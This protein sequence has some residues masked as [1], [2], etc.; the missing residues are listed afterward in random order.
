MRYALRNQSKILDKFDQKYLD[1]II[2]SLDA[3]FKSY[4]E[5]EEIESK[6]ERYP[7]IHVDDVGH[8]VNMFEFYVIKKIYDVYN[9]AFKGIIG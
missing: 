6:G 1:R 8:T 2:R 3:H 5:I 4:K 7:I 9:L